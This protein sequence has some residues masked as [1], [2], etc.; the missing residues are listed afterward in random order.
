V[1]AFAQE[2]G[3]QPGQ[4]LLWRQRPNVAR[5]SCTALPA[6][7]F[8]SPAHQGCQNTAKSG[9]YIAIKEKT[10]EFG[11]QSEFAWGREESGRAR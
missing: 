2:R 6:I 1:E 5:V 3:L 11:C 7:L 10:R 4:K 9:V 8:P